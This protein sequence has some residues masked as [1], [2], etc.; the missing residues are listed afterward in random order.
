[1]ARACVLVADGHRVHIAI[2]GK[3]FEGLAVNGEAVEAGWDGFVFHKVDFKYS[4]HCVAIASAI[5]G[6]VFDLS[7]LRSAC[8]AR[9]VLY[10]QASCVIP[11]LVV[12]VSVSTHVCLLNK[13]SCG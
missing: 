11:V 3:H 12:I 6:N 10:H 8:G 4:L 13:S 1:V 7:L 9:L 5:P 2:N